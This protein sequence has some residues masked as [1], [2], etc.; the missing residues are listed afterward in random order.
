MPMHLHLSPVEKEQKSQ[1]NSDHWN[2]RHVRHFYLRLQ[3]GRF[4]HNEQTRTKEVHWNV[5]MQANVMKYA[6]THKQKY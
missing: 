1:L 6:Q 3:A 2:V 5:Y 4:G